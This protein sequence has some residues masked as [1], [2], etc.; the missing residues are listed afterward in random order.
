[1]PAKQK[2]ARLAAWSIAIAL[3]VLALKTAAWLLTGSVALFSDALES[4]VNVIAAGVALY[5]VRLSHKPA[6]A[7]HPFGHHKAEYLSAVIEGALIIVAALLIFSEAIRALMDPAPLDQPALGLAVNLAAGAVNGA[8]AW[9]LIR[10]GREARSPALVAD[11]RHLYA[12]VVTSVGVIAGLLLALATSFAA[13]DPL[14][15]IAVGLHILREGWKLVNASVQGLMDRALG[16][17][18]LSEIR[19]II[20][21]NAGAAIEHHDLKTR[22]A[23]R[24]RFIEFHLVVPENMAVGEAHDICDR[25]EA[26]LKAAMPHARVVI[27]VEPEGEAKAAPPA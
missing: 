4:V 10:T 23:A 27:H 2:V 20:A 15:A 17:E 26:A 8:W 6:D 9:L 21:A 14:L 16:A 11:G 7:G 25:I 1:M 3:L 22:E 19:A 12:D 18:E 5:A 13:L 24:A